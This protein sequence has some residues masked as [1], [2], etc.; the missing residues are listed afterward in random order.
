[1]SKWHNYITPDELADTAS[2]F[3]DKVLGS[4]KITPEAVIQVAQM[5]SE[6]YSYLNDHDAIADAIRFDVQSFSEYAT[7][8]YIANE[9]LEFAD[10]YASLLAAGHPHNGFNDLEIS[11]KWISG[12]PELTSQAQHAIIAALS[13]KSSDIEQLHANTRL[14]LIAKNGELS[15]DTAEFL[16][17]ALSSISYN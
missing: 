8:G 13:P 14:T 5:A 15:D 4:R 16:E 12:A 7:M 3:N 17:A 6:Y 9:N 10:R 1:M 11:A 2:Y